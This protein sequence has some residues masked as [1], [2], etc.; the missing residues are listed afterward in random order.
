MLILKNARRHHHAQASSRK[1]RSWIAEAEW[2]QARQL[3]I[4]SPI[5]RRQ[6]DFRVHAQHGLKVPRRKDRA[7]VAFQP[8]FE[9]RDAMGGQRET[10]GL[11]VAAEAFEQIAGGAERLKKMKTLDRAARAHARSE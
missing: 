4:K 6:V 1:R 10:R 11:G 8:R 7:R 2:P 3:L 9:F 5:D